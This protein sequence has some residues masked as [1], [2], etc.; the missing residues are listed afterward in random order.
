MSMNTNH[1]ATYAD[2]VRGLAAAILAELRDFHAG[3]L[4]GDLR[5]RLLGEQGFSGA[6]RFMLSETLGLL[7]LQNRVRLCRSPRSRIFI[8]TDQGHRQNNK[9]LDAL[10]KARVNLDALEFAVSWPGQLAPRE[11]ASFLKMFDAVSAELGTLADWLQESKQ[12]LAEAV[13]VCETD[14]NPIS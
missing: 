8:A 5:R 13:A 6:E 10:L 7:I 12:A 14:R 9:L 4:E 3:V 1:E 2:S 11:E